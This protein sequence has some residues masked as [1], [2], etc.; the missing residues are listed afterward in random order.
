QLAAGRNP[1]EGLRALLEP[2]RSARTLRRWADEYLAS[3]LDIDEN[4]RKNYRSALRKASERFGDR[5][6]ARLA[7]DEV[8][9]WVAELAASRK[10]GTVQQNLIALRLLLGFAGCDPNPARDPRV[11]LP[12]RVREEPKPPTAAHVEAILAAMGT[13]WRLLFAMIEQGALR[14]GEAVQLTWGDVD[15]AGPR[16]RLPRSATT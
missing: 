6:P 15:A 12:K 10:P 7:A 11:R 3:R 5:D 2:P 1:A 8:A 13:K 16:L 4:T 9:V 14:L